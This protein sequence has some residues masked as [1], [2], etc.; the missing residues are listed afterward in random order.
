M[1]EPHFDA[2]E[3]DG[4]VEMQPQDGGAAPESSVDHTDE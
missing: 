3:D 4:S 1:T 2:S